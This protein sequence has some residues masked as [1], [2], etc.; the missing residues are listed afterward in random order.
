MRKKG[1]LLAISYNKAFEWSMIIDKQ[2]MYTMLSNLF[3]NGLYG[4][5]QI[6]VD[7]FFPTI[8]STRFYKQVNYREFIGIFR[9]VI[10][11]T[12]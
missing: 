3:F 7:I 5:K 9:I 8:F 10:C 2:I 12:M 1:K 4:L 11:L 6:T